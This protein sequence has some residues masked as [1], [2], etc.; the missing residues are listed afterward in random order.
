MGAGTTS[1]SLREVVRRL[2]EAFL[3]RTGPNVVGR[4]ALIAEDELTAEGIGTALRQR[5]LFPSPDPLRTPE[6]D[7]D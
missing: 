5:E 2:E 3:R 7:E 6:E 1:C 4:G